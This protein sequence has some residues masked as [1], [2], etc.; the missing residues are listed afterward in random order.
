[1]RYL[2]QIHLD[3]VLFSRGGKYDY[4]ITQKITKIMLV[5]QKSVIIY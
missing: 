1:M 3:V 2:L 5:K 4:Y